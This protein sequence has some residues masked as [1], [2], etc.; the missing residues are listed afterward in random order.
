MTLQSWLLD[1]VKTAA[2]TDKL[3]GRPDHLTATASGLVGESG[4]ILVEFKKR[5]REGDAYPAGDQELIEEVGD[6]LWYLARLVDILQFKPEDIFVREPT[7]VGSP[8]STP[9]QDAVAM[10]SAS[11]HVLEAISAHR[12]PEELR[13]MLASVWTC[14]MTVVS[15]SGLD[16]KDVLEKNIHK[17]ESRWPTAENYA[18]LF[19]A[20]HP[21]EEQLPRCLD[22]EFRRSAHGPDNVVILRC[23][24]LNLGDRLTD[25]IKGGDNYRFHDIFHFAYAVY[26]GWSPVLRS[27]LRCKR[28]SDPSDDENE[29]GAR[30][31]IIEEAISA[32]VFARAKELDMYRNVEQVDY[33]LLKLIQRFV[34]GF[35]VS[36]VP[37]WQWEKAILEGFRT[38]RQL[39]RYGGGM[40]RL[41]MSAHSLGYSRPPH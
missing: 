17:R 21:E 18:A 13:E 34:S 4:G 1:Y 7:C 11:A 24:G 23:N 5:I 29:D 30:A 32:T 36:R 35:E 40:V 15:A 31:Q 20:D 6:A 2:R 38:F 10:S 26:L 3:I 22:V 27:L 8:C 9:L 14:T 39:S 28:K 33:D 37:L 12:P 19:D 16:L 25:N 41:D